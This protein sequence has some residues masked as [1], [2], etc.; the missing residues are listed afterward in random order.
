MKAFDGANLNPL[1]QNFNRQLRGV[2]QI[3][4]RSI[5]LLK[6]RF[7]C[8]MGERKLRYMPKKVGKFIYACAILHNFLILNRFDIFRDIDRNASQNVVNDGHNGPNAHVPQL[9][10]AA[11]QIRRNELA[12]YLQNMHD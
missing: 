4:E 7:R 8:I 3:V 10:F 6:V 12:I 2:R 1:Q 5:G 9:N 11:G